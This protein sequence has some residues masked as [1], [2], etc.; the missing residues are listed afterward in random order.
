MSR[1]PNRTLPSEVYLI[2]HAQRWPGRL[3]QQSGMPIGLFRSAGSTIPMTASIASSTTRPNA[4]V[5]EFPSRLPDGYGRAPVTRRRMPKVESRKV[6]SRL[7]HH[8]AT[9]RRSPAAELDY[10]NPASAGALRNCFGKG[11]VGGRQ[12]GSVSRHVR[13]GLRPSGRSARR[14]D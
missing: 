6:C 12:E 10:S 9:L 7:T 4:P 11:L 5:P 14:L 8:V 13:P 1:S 2:S 3:H